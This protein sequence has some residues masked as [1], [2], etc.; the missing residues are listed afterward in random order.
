MWDEE[1]A[2]PDLLAAGAGAGGPKNH[3]EVQTYIE[4]APK[5]TQTGDDL[6]A[7]VAKPMAKLRDLDDDDKTRSA[8]IQPEC[9]MQARTRKHIA[10]A[11][12]CT[13]HTHAPCVRAPAC[14]HAHAV[15]CT[16]AHH[17]HAH[18]M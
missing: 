17:T 5:A 12:A 4:V 9:H 16:H 18:T 2:S 15:S 3:K 13:V 1:D 10:C 14:T 11:C 8:K 6:S 7:P